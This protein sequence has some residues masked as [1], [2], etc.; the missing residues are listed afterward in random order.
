MKTIKKL[1]FISTLLLAV[2]SAFAQQS[3]RSDKTFT[4][5]DKLPEF[6][7]DMGNYLLKNL[8]YPEAAQKENVQGKTVLKFLISETGSIREI[9]VARSAGAILDAEAIRVVRNMPE[10]KPGYKNGK[11]VAVYYTLP[12]SFRL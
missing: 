10:W 6:P 9:E 8:V 2:H 3:Q 4:Y 11:A 12:I 1:L 5:V 7:E